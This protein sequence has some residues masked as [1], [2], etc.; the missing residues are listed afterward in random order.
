MREDRK[1]RRTRR[2]GRD[3]KK[4]IEDGRLR[5]KGG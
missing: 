5:E 4:E 2:K 3:D 1:K